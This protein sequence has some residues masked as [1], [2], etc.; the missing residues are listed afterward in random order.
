MQQHYL[1]LRNN[2]QLGPFTIEE[3]LNQEL[4]PTDLV[5]ING[6]STAWTYAFELN[7]LKLSRKGATGAQSK[8][9]PSQSA[10]PTEPAAKRRRGR[11]RKDEST[12]HTPPHP[13]ADV[14]VGAPATPAPFFADDLEAKAEQIRQRALAAERSHFDRHPTPV[15]DSFAPSLSED[16]E[17]IQVVYHKKRSH[18]PLPQLFVGTMVVGMLIAGWYGQPLFRA[19]KDTVNAVAT[20]LVSTQENTAAASRTEVPADSGVNS[21]PVQDSVQPMVASYTGSNVSRPKPGTTKQ[22]SESDVKPAV[23]N[24]VTDAPP[25]VVEKKT[26]EQKSDA[27]TTPIVVTAKKEPEEAPST[28]ATTEQ[29]EK[30]RSFLKG[31][32]K[33]KK[34]GEASLEGEEAKPVQTDTGSRKASDQ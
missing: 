11:P 3:L 26:E 17:K 16:D 5:W 1:L 20:P 12:P 19:K 23:E 32:F 29:P 22:L 6:Q 2:T 13:T 21:L 4:L 24:P 31:L 34:K 14:P 30:K 28:E 15:E 9:T 10:L 25:P 8:S 7:L 27:H 33:K 18:L